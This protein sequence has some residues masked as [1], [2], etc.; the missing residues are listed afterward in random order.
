MKRIIRNLVRDPLAET[1]QKYLLPFGFKETITSVMPKERRVSDC[2]GIEMILKRSGK[3]IDK[4][5][6]A[7]TVDQK[8]TKYEIKQY[9]EKV[10][11]IEV[12]KVNSLIKGGHIKRSQGGRR[13]RESDTKKAYITTNQ[14]VPEEFRQLK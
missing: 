8:L 7:V 6:F 14:E 13:F 9:L 12:V 11:D 2:V 10:Y 5:E 3:K 1:R 4:K